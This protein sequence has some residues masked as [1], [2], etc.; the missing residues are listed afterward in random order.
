LP[1]SS[2]TQTDVAPTETSKPTKC[3]IAASPSRC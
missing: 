1:T 3:A 2:M